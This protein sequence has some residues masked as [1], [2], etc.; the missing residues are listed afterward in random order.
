MKEK[1]LNIPLIRKIAD[2]KTALWLRNHP[3]FGKFCSYEMIMYIL[4]GVLTTVVNY[5]TYFLLPGDFGA[6]G[7]VVRN[8]AAWVTAVVFGYFV[9]KIFVFESTSWKA[10]TVLKEFFSF[11]AARI[12]SF[13]FETVFLFVTVTLLHWNEP[14]MKILSNVV[15]LI[16]NYIASKFII[17]RKKPE[18]KN[19]SRGD[20]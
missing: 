7:V 13:G 15:V 3:V 19:A 20:M 11:V 5:V 14:L 8:S 4:C 9:N 18:D 1:I 10:G 12:L 17:F 16:M 6:Y 2:T